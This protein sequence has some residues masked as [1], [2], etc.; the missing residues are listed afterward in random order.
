MALPGWGTLV[1]VIASQFS[2]REERIRNNILKLKK[3]RDELN[4]K[5]PN[6]STKYS[7]IITKLQLE[8]TKLQNR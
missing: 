5:D 1:G 8:E 6:Y 2:T 3:E 7:V 4:P